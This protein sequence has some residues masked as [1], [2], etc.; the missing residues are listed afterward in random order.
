ME[1]FMD[2][3]C[4]VGV[5]YPTF[6]E[7]PHR[8]TKDAIVPFYPEDPDLHYSADD[9]KAFYVSRDIKALLLINPDNPSG[10]FIPK[11]DVLSLAAWSSSCS[12]NTL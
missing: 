6:E 9:L 11:D 7:Y 4:M 12:A 10:N 2:E 3:D 5:V 8:L 1:L